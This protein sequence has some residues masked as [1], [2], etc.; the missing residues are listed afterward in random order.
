MKP[1]EL[2]EN[3]IG[4]IDDDLL[5]DAAQ[6]RMRKPRRIP[7]FVAAACL[8]MILLIIPIGILLANQTETPK[9]PI[10]DTT[11]SSS[12]TTTT[13]ITTPTPITTEKPKNSVLDIPSA[14]LFVNDGS[15]QTE[16][17]KG[18]TANAFYSFSDTQLHAW[19]NRIKEENEAVVGIVK[20]YTSVLIPDGKAY[21]RVTTMEIEVL[22]DFSGIKSETV[23]AV[24]VCRYEPYY[25]DYYPA[26]K[27]TVGEGTL[28]YVGDKPDE[29]V[30]NVGFK[31]DMFQQ[32][33]S[34]PSYIQG[35]PFLLLKDAKDQTVT[36]ENE[37]YALSDYADYVLDACLQYETGVDKMYM[38]DLNISLTATSAL[39]REV[40]LNQIS[41]D[42]G[43]DQPFFQ[44]RESYEAFNGNV[45]MRLNLYKAVERLYNSSIFYDKLFI[46]TDE[47]SETKINPAYTWV[48][49]IDG[50]EYTIKRFEIIDS[51]SRTKIYLDLGADFSFDLFAYD[52]NNRYTYEN[53]RL[54]IYDSE[55]NLLCYSL[56]T[57]NQRLEGG[58]TH[59]KKD[60]S[61]PEP[62]HEP[63]DLLNDPESACIL[64]VND[65]LCSFDNTWRAF[66]GN[67]AFKFHID[68]ESPIFGYLFQETYDIYGNPTGYEPRIVYKWVITVDGVSYEVKRLSVQTESFGKCIYLDLGAEFAHDGKNAYDDVKLEIFYNVKYLYY[69]ADFTN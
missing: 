63:I 6:A 25:G 3:A 16:P 69:Y 51:S 21:Y 31:L 44:F 58:Y 18:L 39:L 12:P 36:I 61:P 9:V 52:E 8:T 55:G 41:F 1:N 62:N 29:I 60:N 22:E 33:L 68:K 37:T 2:L 49:T 57:N 53:M 32:A 30:P 35:V 27:Y 47:R 28:D 26:T 14:E 64:S 20:S 50:V 24:S 7:Y 23:N 40:F 5:F 38:R 54:D 42:N 10:V 59:T 34:A 67:T 46:D 15:F 43:P 48:V 13:A 17:G 66:D 56:L 11:T 4:K 45:A 19:A 65:A